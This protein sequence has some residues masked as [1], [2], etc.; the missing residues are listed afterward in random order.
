MKKTI[1]INKIEG[2]LRAPASKSVAQRALAI[3]SLAHGQSRIMHVG[4][5]DD[6]IAAIGVIQALGARVQK[7]DDTVVVEGGITVPRQVLHCGESGLGIRMFAAVAATMNGEVVLTGSGSLSGRPMDMIVRSLLAAGVDCSSQNGFVP[8][9][10]NGPI[11]GG[12]VEVD[13]SVSSQVLTGLLIA[14]PYAGKPVEIYVQDL[15]SRPYV[16]ITT[17]MMQDFGVATQ[18]ENY[19]IFRI[20][21][22]AYYA[23][24]DYV[25]E[26]DWSGAAFWL[27]AAAMAG[28]IK[29]DNLDVSSPQADKAI[30]EALQLCGAQVIVKGKQVE[31]HKAPL[32]GFT[33]DATHCPDLFPPLV[34]LASS[35][36]GKTMIKGVGR[37][38]V[39]E[40]DRALA[41]KTEFGKMGMDIV[42][43][44][45][46]MIISG[47]PLKGAEV[48]SHHDHRI[49]MA[50][51]I[52]S[53]NSL[54]P[55]VIQ[56]AQA[57][58]K[59][60]PAFYEHL[61]KVCV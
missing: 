13:G 22:P 48:H 43:E 30:L 56:H 52:A 28:S 55:V 20:P 1:N 61:D 10:V 24:R 16:D 29:L 27:V 14:A 23:G 60:Y 38:R 15:K 39:K 40:S 44:D 34:A 5:S 8:V 35:C 9:R 37:L 25:V 41:L 11:P 12:K 36:E 4:D 54:G 31:V 19:E 49:A 45:D 32:K 53:L 59:S 50:A 21:A 6:V 47:A 3:A 2:S 7:V 46:M 58:A 42:L 57:V 33:F 18:N 17:R 26:G 51:A